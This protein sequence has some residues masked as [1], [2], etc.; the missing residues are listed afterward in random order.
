MALAHRTV[1]EAA[2]A[3]LLPEQ[4]LIPAPAQEMVAME[5]H[6]LFPVRLLPMLVVA[7]VDLQLLA[8]VVLVVGVLVARLILLEL[9]ELQTPEAV[10]AAVAVR[11]EMVVMAV[12]V[13]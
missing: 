8:Q 2:V 3:R 13:S 5:L 6:H 4:L 11:V 1:V 9:L 12:Q 7:V 10:E